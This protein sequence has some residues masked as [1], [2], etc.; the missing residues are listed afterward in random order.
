MAWSL[1]AVGSY[2][3]NTGFATGVTV[4]IPGGAMAGDVMVMVGGKG[5]SDGT[6]LAVDNGWT[7]AGQTNTGS[8]RCCIAYKVHSGSESNPTLTSGID[9]GNIAG[10]IQVWRSDSPLDT[11]DVLV[12][13][14]G[15]GFFTT[16]TADADFANG[17]L[18]PGDVVI[19][20][21]N[22]GQAGTLTRPTDGIDAPGVTWAGNHVE[23]PASN[24]WTNA[25]GGQHT[26]DMGYRIV[27]TG[28]SSGAP[29]FNSTT[30]LEYPAVVFL[31]LR[32]NPA[33]II[34]PDVPGGRGRPGDVTVTTG[35]PVVKAFGP[36]GRG[37]PATNVRVT[38]EGPATFLLATPRRDR[39]RLVGWD[40]TGYVRGDGSPAEDGDVPVWHPSRPPTL[41][42]PSAGGASALDDLTDVNAPSPG[43]GEVLT[44][45]DA[46]GEWVAAP[47]ATGSGNVV[48]VW[49]D[50]D[51]GTPAQDETLW[52][53]TDDDSPVASGESSGTV[54][55]S[56]PT[57][58]MRFYRTD[59]H[60]LYQYVA[61]AWVEATADT[62]WHYVGGSG[63]PAFLNS[64]VNYDATAWGGCAF[65]RIGDVVY[66]AGL[67]KNGN[68][69][70]AIFNLPAGYRPD[71]LNGTG[72]A[73]IFPVITNSAMGRVDVRST[74]D[75]NAGNVVANGVNNAWVSLNSIRFPTSDPWP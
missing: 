9:G 25:A 2:A 1:V 62:G 49:D 68:T 36:G 46:A 66:L 59:R 71:N 26:M 37:R 42:E 12:K 10:V 50:A 33:I 45:D 19:A 7:V 44:W 8:I 65:R 43:D 6:P 48:G 53:D 27:D 35:P 13:T 30:S 32:D 64:W 4:G 63:E 51:P 23:S 73:H 40:G 24:Y 70:L 41:E 11:I 57:S 75:A 16:V 39:P 60:A 28:A 74:G 31:R 29:E 61:G 17:G 54:F 18:E 38:A 22:T 52:Y 67:V 72:N 20:G 5:N 69:S 21:C 56:S 15:T 58:G 14:P 3:A 47:G 55:P 34:E